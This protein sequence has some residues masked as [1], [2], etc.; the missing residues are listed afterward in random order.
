MSIKIDNSNK[1]KQSCMCCIYCGKAY[2]SRASIDKHLILCETIH[3]SKNM[4]PTQD[5][6]EMPSQLQMYNIILELTMKCNKLEEKMEQ[7]TKWIDKKKKK[8]NV[9][10][11]LNTNINPELIFDDLSE[12]I[13][14]LDTDI[15]NILN[16][17]FLEVFNEVFLREVFLK[18]EK[19]T[20]P[21]FCLDQKVN[22]IYVFNKNNKENEN[23]NGWI[24]LDKG[25]LIIFMNKIHKKII[26]KLTDWKKQLEREKNFNDS[27]S[28][29]Y[30]KTLMKLMNLNFKQDAVINKVKN[31]IY[32]QIKTDMTSIIEYEFDF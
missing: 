5:D 29:L 20:I 11:W 19:Q 24:E 21:I 3:K 6:I 31:I 2:K 27:K 28:E 18:K 22:Y 9:L 25:E 14:I 1:I 26:I 17:G 10:E 32:A 12:K 15:E 8:I 4:S 7:M 23:T 16:T 30:N 13:T